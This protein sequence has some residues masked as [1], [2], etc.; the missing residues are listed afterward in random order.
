MSIRLPRG[1]L[2]FDPAGALVTSLRSAHEPEGSVVDRFE[3]A[4]ADALRA[5]HAIA[6]PHARIALELI[7]RVLALPKG[8]RVLMS[9]VTIPEIVSVVSI[10]GLVPVFVDLGER[11]C[12]VDCDALE[13]QATAE[14]SAILLTHLAG[15][16]SDM[17]RISALAQRRRLALIEDC[18]Q[19][20]GATWRGRPLGLFGCAG[21]M[22]LT[23]LKPV[24]TLHGGLTITADA[25]M[26]QA[27]RSLANE[28]GPP[29]SRT[30]LARLFFRDSVLHGVTQKN[31][32]AALTYHCVRAAERFGPQYVREFQRGNFFNDRALASVSRDTAMPGWRYARYS[33]FQAGLGLHG[34]ESL[35]AGNRRRREL[36]TLLLEL[37]GA[38]GVRGTVRV[39]TEGESVFWRFP[40]WVDDVPRFRR[41]LL[42]RGIDSS[43]TNLPCLSRESAFAEFAA[44]TPNA[45]A[46]VDG[47]VFLPM[48]S[49]LTEADMRQLSAVVSEYQRA[50]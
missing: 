24:S 46:Y 38:A 18:S 40:L 21:F 32:F 9:A 26:A 50:S 3:R 31:I 14:C 19:A 37:L 17:D 43:S 6:L 30:A 12:N 44:D 29:L 27:L 45:R 48:H 5:P 25:A 16:P 11:T 1:Q 36:S 7:L 4:F 2:Y 23:P 8:S 34:L 42:E 20:P 35:A 15:L 33:D 49:N 28:L 41:F 13:R 10:A 22:S 39:P 47:M